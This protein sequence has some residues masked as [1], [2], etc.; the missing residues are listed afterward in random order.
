MGKIPIKTKAQQELM[1]EGGKRLSEIKNKLEKK[2]VEGVSA[3]E[4]EELA[5][6]LIKKSGGEASFAMVEGYNWATCINV[7]DGVVHG[8]PSSDIVFKTGDLVSIDVG[9]YYKKMHTD[10]SI[11]FFVGSLGTVDAKKKRFFD[12]GKSALNKAIA[13][14][15]AKMH[16]YDI[17]KAIETTVKNAGF[18]P[19][20]ALVGHG[21]GKLLHEEPQI[22]CFTYIK[23]ESTAKIVPGMVFAIEV[24]YNMGKKDVVLASDGWT[25]KT[26]DGKI[27]GLFEETVLVTENGPLVLT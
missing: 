18:S 5:V 21:V 7:N 15:E 20:E 1:R 3:S 4:V 9:L 8:I 22:P 23:R 24:M 10:T 14:C 11:S 17:S 19:V 25:I 12:I 16:V 26:A 27:A 13:A 6:K 2:A